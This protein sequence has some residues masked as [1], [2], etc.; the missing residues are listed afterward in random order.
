MAKKKRCPKH[1]WDFEGL[2]RPM[3]CIRCGKVRFPKIEECV[4]SS[5]DLDYFEGF[6]GLPGMRESD[7]S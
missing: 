5:P 6:S 2:G 7:Y 4:K 1:V 3:K